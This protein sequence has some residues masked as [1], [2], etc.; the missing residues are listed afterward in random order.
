MGL[1]RTISDLVKQQYSE[2]PKGIKSFSR[3][4]REPVVTIELMEEINE[5]KIISIIEDHDY[6]VDYEDGILNYYETENNGKTKLL[7]GTLH[8]D[9]EIAIGEKSKLTKE[10]EFVIEYLEEK[11]GDKD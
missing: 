3:R 9:R 5:D 8:L 1:K 10:A 11:Y 2:Y 6:E 4:Y 7:V